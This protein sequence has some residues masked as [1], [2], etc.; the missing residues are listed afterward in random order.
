MRLSAILTELFVL[1]L[2]M[3]FRR[4]LIASCSALLLAA[5]GVD[6]TGLSADLHNQPHPQTSANAAVT[7]IEY[8][9]LQCPACKAAHTTIVKPLIEKYGTQIRYEFRHLPLSSI[10]RFAIDAA[11]AAECAADQGKFW[12]FVDIVYERQDTLSRE[13]LTEWGNELELDMDLFGRCRDSHIKRDAIIASYD[14]G[15]GKGVTGT[16]TFFVNG[17]RVESDL[18]AISKAIDD[19]IG[20][21]GQRL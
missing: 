9:D 20:T 8:A 3:T 1:H 5:C 6:T 12:E 14:E 11:E 2:F 19:A 4:F 17:T 13:A 7:V 18:A 21:A 16:P 10:H 15:R